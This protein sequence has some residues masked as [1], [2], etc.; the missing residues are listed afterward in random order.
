MRS[1][2]QDGGETLRRW[3]QTHR[4]NLIRLCGK[5]SPTLCLDEINLTVCCRY[6]ETLIKHDRINRYLGKHHPMEVRR[7]Q[8][9]LDDLERVCGKRDT[10]TSL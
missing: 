9:L 4:A 1:V 6:A 3:R 10:E 7:L 8:E 5:H 2:K